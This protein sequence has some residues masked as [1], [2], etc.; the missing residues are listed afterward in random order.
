MK[1]A[2]NT[3]PYSSFPTFLPTYTLDETIRSIAEAGYDAV[4]IGCCAPH[5]WP[6]HLAKDRRQEIRAIA[7]GEGLEISALLPAIGGGFGCNPC[8]S[9]RAERQAT[10]SHYIDIIDLASDLGAG[11]V[12]YIGG[13]RAQ[14]MSLEAGWD[15]SA[16][17]LRQIAVH[18]Q[19]RGIIIAIEPTT[20]DTNLIDTPADARRMME[21]VGTSN[22]KLM[23]DTFHMDFE[24]GSFA[25]YVAEMGADLVNIHMADTQRKAIGEG[26]TDWL[27]RMEALVTAN[28]TGNV[29]VE[30][31]FGRRGADPGEVA[32]VSLRHLQNA[33]EAIT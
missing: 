9:S 29:T 2:F 33:L 24:G 6:Q 1:F 15:Y 11:M 22:V 26:T 16:E 12:L 14:G 8:S 21:A 5:A 18:A 27:P 23:F 31:G 4:E 7:G 25:D 3:F 13:W 20:S 19:D 17:C 10:V 32:R 28:Y 30:T